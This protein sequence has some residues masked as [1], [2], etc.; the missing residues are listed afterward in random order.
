[1]L[2]SS[3]TPK[4]ILVLNQVQPFFGKLLHCALAV[5]SAAVLAFNKGMQFRAPGRQAPPSS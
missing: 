5:H 2:K 1:M 3:S 4:P